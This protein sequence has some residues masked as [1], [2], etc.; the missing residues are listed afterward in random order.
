MPRSTRSAWS[1]DAWGR[2]LKPFRKVEAARIRYL[3]VAEAKRLINAADRESGFRD[4]V[5]AALL[6]GCRYGELARLTVADFDPDAGTVA[7][8]QSKSGRPRHVFLTDEGVAHLSALAA[9]A[10]RRAAAALSP[11][12]PPPRRRAWLP[13]D[14]VRPMAEAVTPRQDRAADLVPGLR[15]TYASL[16]VM[17]GV[18][19]Q[20]VARNW[21]RR[22]PH[23]REHYGHLEDSY[24]RSAI[25]EGAPSSARKRREHEDDPMTNEKLPRW[26]EERKLMQWLA[27]TRRRRRG[28]R[29]K[30]AQRSARA[31]VQTLVRTR[32][33]LAKAEDLI[34]KFAA[35]AVLRANGR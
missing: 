34:W 27:E 5:R 21:P 28:G 16:A 2:R 31:S 4:L 32:A 29:W 25:R 7:V 9:G 3:R 17:N 10:G 1:N 18:P 19:L 11:A 12:P 20:V 22:Y 30:E 23:G 15:H 8:R 26:G 14:Q 24:I 35:D 6:T 13:S 33:G